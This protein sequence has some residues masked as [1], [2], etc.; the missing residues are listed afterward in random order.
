[1]DAKRWLPVELVCIRHAQSIGNEA[2]KRARQ[3]DLTIYT[4]EFRAIASANWRL[5]P[6]GADDA[7]RIGTLLRA[8]IRFPFTHYMVSP[9]VRTIE[10]AGNLGIPGAKWSLELYS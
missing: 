1:M 5:T 3:G 6:R 2:G 4:P 10:T 8:V 9:L 7:R